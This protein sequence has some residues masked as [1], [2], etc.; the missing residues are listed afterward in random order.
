MEQ[1]SRPS[2][3]VDG[4]NIVVLLRLKVG[5]QQGASHVLFDLLNRE[6]VESSDWSKRQSDLPIIRMMLIMARS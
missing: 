1:A 2:L 4:E 6:L 3:A 5:D